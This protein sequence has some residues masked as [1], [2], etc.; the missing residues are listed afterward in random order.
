MRFVTLAVTKV[1]K[2]NK[3]TKKNGSIF[4]KRKT[5]KKALTSATAA[6]SIHNKL[7]KKSRRGD[8]KKRE[9]QDH[10][11]CMATRE[12]RE[13]QKIGLYRKIK[14]MSGLSENCPHRNDIE[15]SMV[16]CGEI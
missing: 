16:S 8:R 7:K 6:K 9:R 10:S 2:K 12:A 3:Q 13:E 11:A 1:N 5:E 14:Q 4:T 15:A